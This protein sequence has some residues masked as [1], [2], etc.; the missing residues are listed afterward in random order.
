MKSLSTCFLILVI[1]VSSLLSWHNMIY[2]VDTLSPFYTDEVANVQAIVS[3]LSKGAYIS[4]RYGPLYSSG[5][6]ATWP[7]AIGWFIGHS[8]FASRLAA[9]FFCWLL[10]LV[11]GYWFFRRN[12]YGP[13][14][15]IAAPVCIWGLSITAPLAIP[16]W[17]GFMYTL[18]ELNTVI[19]IGF[20]I[21]LLS[22]H[23]L[24]SMIFFGLAF[25]HGKFSFFLLVTAVVLGDILSQRLSMQRI[26]HR[27]LKYGIFFSMPLIIWLVWLCL[28]FDLAMIKQ[29]FAYTW[30]WVD[31][32]PSF[33]VE[34]IPSGFSW[35]VLKQRLSSPYCEWAGY[36]LGTKIKDLFLTLGAIGVTFVGLN[37][38]KRKIIT[39]SEREKW[40]SAM[41]AFS[42]LFYS[43]F[44]FF[45]HS[46]M[47]QRHLQAAVYAG[48][49]LFIFWGSKWAR[50]CSYNLRWFFYAAAVLLIVLQAVSS[51]KH[52]IFQHQ[53]TYSRSCTD[54][55]SSKCDPTIYK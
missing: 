33:Y 4:D 36:T 13:I 54:L 39:I 8:L 2:Q 42:I 51:A 28:R 49:G 35:D 22:R 41:L 18:G 48:F 30:Q 25:W 23:P 3:F 55:Y 17:F 1:I 52:P 50:S 7:S 14:E 5:I 53:I 40:I 21:L 44:Y 6:A 34:G 19:L 43:S 10:A 45:I 46:V 27:L 20:G 16:Y 24:L 37:L 26:M 9:A 32:N 38:A 11:L 29:W 15:S 12:G 31:H 47:W